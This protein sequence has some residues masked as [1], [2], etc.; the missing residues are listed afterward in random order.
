MLRRF[1][2]VNMVC[3]KLSF[4][5][6]HAHNRRRFLFAVYRRARRAEQHGCSRRRER[7]RGAARFR[8]LERNLV[9][10]GVIIIYCDAV[11]RRTAVGGYDYGIP[12]PWILY[13]AFFPVDFVY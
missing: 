3:C 11:Y 12:A 9:Y 2:W 13:C 8:E 7:Q 1:S 6:A 10:D 5:T 4:M